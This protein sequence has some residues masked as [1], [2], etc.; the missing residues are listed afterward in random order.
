M[1][2]C[3]SNEGCTNQATRWILIEYSWPIL[4]NEKRTYLL[5]EDHFSRA[6]QSASDQMRQYPETGIKIIESGSLS[7]N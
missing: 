5:C 4:P 7:T 2:T 1:A 3:Q 6:E